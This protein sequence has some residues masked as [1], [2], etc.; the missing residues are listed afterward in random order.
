MLENGSNEGQN[1]DG[2][3][4]G[5]PDLRREDFRQSFPAERLDFRCVSEEDIAVRKGDVGKV[6]ILNYCRSSL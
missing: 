2:T 6:E 1:A 4:Y 3:K 5:E